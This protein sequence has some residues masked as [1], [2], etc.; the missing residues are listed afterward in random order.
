MSNYQKISI[1]DWALEDRPR[2]KLQKNGISVL[3]NSEL[4]AILIGSGTRDIS[5]V[6]LSKQILKLCNNNLGELGKFNI[7]D[8]TKVKGIGPAK[9]ISIIAALELGKRRKSEDVLI[10]N[11]ITASKD[12]ADIFSSILSDLNHEEFWVLLLNRSNK[13]IEKNKLSQGGIAGTVIDVRL[14]LKMAIEKVT[15]AVIICHNHPSGNNLPSESDK[16][17]TKKV[18]E[19]L[20]LVDIQLLDHIIIAGRNFYSFADEGV[21]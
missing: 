11:K 15:T 18:K 7:N 9:A 20:I 16:A 6:E 19:A 4:I 13:I 12:V 10:R 3:S 1:K 2:E 14:L 21:L 8:L 5:A 17:I